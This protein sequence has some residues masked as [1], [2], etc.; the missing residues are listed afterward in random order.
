MKQDTEKCKSSLVCIHKA[1][2]SHATPQVLHLFGVN[3]RLRSKIQRRGKRNHHVCS[4]L[5]TVSFFFPNLLGYI[6]IVFNTH[7]MFNNYFQL[8]YQIS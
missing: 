5:G 2:M 3:A 6:V 1:L 8:L 7:L 4:K